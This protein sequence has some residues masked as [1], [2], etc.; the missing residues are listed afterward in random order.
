MSNKGSS[1]M[2]GQ[3]SEESV[4]FSLGSFAGLA[5]VRR[6]AAAPASEG[7]GLI[8]IRAM[9]AMIDS[10]TSGAA[11]GRGAD[12]EQMI[13][14][15]GGGGFNALS[16]EP[17]PT[18]APATD[19]AS[20]PEPRESRAPLYILVAVLSLGLLGF[21]AI[22]LFDE[23][24]P[25]QVTNEA[26][27][28]PAAIE[29]SGS[30]APRDQE[31]AQATETETEAAPAEAAAVDAK[32]RK[33]RKRNKP[34]KRNKPRPTKATTASP[35]SPAK[36]TPKSASEVD[37]DCLLNEDLPK[38]KGSAAKVGPEPNQPAPSSELA[39]KLDQS[40]I[41]AG[42]R[43][44]KAAAKSCGTGATVAIKFSVKG[45]TGAVISARPLDEH[46]S[47]SVGK[48]VANSVKGASFAKFK[49]K[50]QGFTFKFRL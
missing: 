43:P 18:V 42:I 19:P 28:V 40:Q 16:A 39:N 29:D 4:L 33:P 49:A 31:A 3:R 7:S 32:P 21:G 45:S 15:F 47:S 36:A 41:L 6:P 37:V 12:P 34:S 44:V 27:A 48:C 38:C 5:P 10:G 24:D 46:A 35:A 14:S 30:E 20:E 1:D 9:R 17:L 2:T 11:T 50:Q 26:I 8:D 13:P 22:I 25:P 23:P